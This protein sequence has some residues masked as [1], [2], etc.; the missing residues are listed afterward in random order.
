MLIYEYRCQSCGHVFAKLQ[1]MGATGEDLD[2][3][4]C[5]GAEIERQLSTFASAS[6]QPATS[7]GACGPST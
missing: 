1:R 5:N 2:C 6:S 3:P 4:K 7:S